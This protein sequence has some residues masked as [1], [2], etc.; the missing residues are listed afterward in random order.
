MPELTLHPTTK[1]VQLD[2]VLCR[3]WEGQTSGGLRVHAFIARVACEQDADAS[4]L[5]AV[6]KETSAPSME[7]AVYPARM[8]LHG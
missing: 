8:V 6:L 5:E 3:V 7:I 1:L 2:N 4:E